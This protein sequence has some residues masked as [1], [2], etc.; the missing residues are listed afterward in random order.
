MLLRCYIM[1]AAIETSKNRQQKIVTF[2]YTYYSFICL[3][4]K[5]EARFTL[6]YGG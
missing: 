3:H 4:K 2:T 1:S 5:T 6:Y